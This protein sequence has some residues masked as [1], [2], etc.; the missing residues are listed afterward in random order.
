MISIFKKEPPTRP[1]Q[2]NADSLPFVYQSEFYSLAWGKVHHGFYILPDGTKYKYREPEQWNFHTTKEHEAFHGLNTSWGYETD[3]LIAPNELFENLV[4]SKE[5]VP[6]FNFMRESNPINASILND[7]QGAE[8]I[9]Y[10]LLATDQG[11][12]S[13]SVLV[14]NGTFKQYKRILLTSNGQRDK[15]NQSDYTKTI[16]D[17]LGEADRKLY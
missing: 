4:N 11:T 10:G 15:V 17:A 16:I 6:L 3:G 7:L 12:L 8:I 5:E 14:Y 13:N 2:F 9:D 1:N